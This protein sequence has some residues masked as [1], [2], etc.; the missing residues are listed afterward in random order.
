VKIKLFLAIV[1]LLQINIAFPQNKNP[2]DNFLSKDSIA[3]VDIIKNISDSVLLNSNTLYWH[4]R[5][6]L[7]YLYY[8]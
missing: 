5:L 6:G 3:P 8:N 7:G 1:F 4:W 2:A